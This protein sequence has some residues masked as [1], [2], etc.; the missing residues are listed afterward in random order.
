LGS[1]DFGR[2]TLDRTLELDLLGRGHCLHS[3][4]LRYLPARRSTNG[5]RSSATSPWNTKNEIP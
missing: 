4:S 2:T 1:Q 3:D 5:A